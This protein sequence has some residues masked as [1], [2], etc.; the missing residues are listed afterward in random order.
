MGTLLLLSLFFSPAG[1][2]GPLAANPN[3]PPPVGNSR[4]VLSQPV[5]DAQDG[6]G[7][8]DPM[9]IDGPPVKGRVCMKIRAFIFET[10]DDQVPKFV[11]ETTCPPAT[12]STKKINKDAQPKLVPA[13][14]GS[15][16]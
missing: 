16:F 10:N 13:D 15:H 14:G 9:Q 7:N 3:P 12:W 8:F 5:A 11:R 2:S 6:V 1:S 4:V